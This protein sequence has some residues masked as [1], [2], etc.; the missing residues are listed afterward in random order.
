MTRGQHT[1]DSMTRTRH[2]EHCTDTDGE[3][4]AQRCVLAAYECGRKKRRLRSS[5]PIDAVSCICYTRRHYAYGMEEGKDRNGRGGRLILGDLVR[6]GKDRLGCDWVET[7][8]TVGALLPVGSWLDRPGYS[9]RMRLVQ[10]FFSLCITLGT[11][12]CALLLDEIAAARRESGR[13]W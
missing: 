13:R 1:Y 7:R 2:D 4:H 5:L 3:R 8:T 11:I 12:S 9:S 6:I 10:S